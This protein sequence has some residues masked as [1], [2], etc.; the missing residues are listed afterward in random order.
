VTEWVRRE[1]I[2]GYEEHPSL[3]HEMMELFKNGM[4]PL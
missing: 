2:P 3:T 4:Q 1:D